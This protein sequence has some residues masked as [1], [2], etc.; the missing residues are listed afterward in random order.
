MTKIRTHK[1]KI[2]WI[3]CG[4]L[5]LVIINGNNFRYNLLT[6]DYTYE[7]NETNLKDAGSWELFPFIIDD[8][9]G[10]DYT[11]AEAVTEEW[12]SG[13]GTSINPYIIENIMIDGLDSQN[14]IT[15]RYS[16]AYFII[17]DSLFYNGRIGINLYGAP[18][19]IIINNTI[20]SNSG[21]GIAL[22]SDLLVTENTIYSNGGD[23]IYLTGNGNTISN[24]VI[25]NNNICGI[26]LYINSD[27]N[28]ISNNIMNDSGM[29]LSGANNNVITGNI[30][31]RG[32]I[33]L[34][35]AGASYGCYNN[36]LTGNI[37]NNGGVE[38]GG[39]T[40][41]EVAS[42]HI[43][44]TNLV[45]GKPLY[46]YTNEIGLDI[47]DFN[48]AGQVIL[49]NCRDSL[50]SNLDVSHT[51][52]IGDND[53]SSG[54]LLYYSSNNIISD[55]NA[56]F[57]NTGIELIYS[58]DNTIKDNNVSNNN[59]KGI[60]TTY[61]NDIIISGNIANDNI[62]YGINLF[63]G[64]GNLVSGN[65]ANN[66]QGYDGISLRL[67]DNNIVLRNT[68][69]N[70]ENCGIR[71]RGINN[72]I[73][74]N[75]ANYNEQ[76]I[77]IEV[78]YNNNNIIGNI[79]NHNYYDGMSIKS[80]Y[81]TILNNTVYNNGRFGIDLYLGK[82]N[83]ITNNTVKDNALGIR[84][85][86]SDNNLIYNNFFIG[87]NINGKDDGTNNQWDNGTIGNYWDDYEGFDNNGDGIG[88]TQYSIDGT[89]GAVDNYPIWDL[90]EPDPDLPTSFTLTSNADTP[91]TDGI[92]TLYWTNS[93][94][95]NNYSLYQNDI[96]LDSGLTEL[97]YL[98]EIYSNGSYSF[99]VIAFNN[100][101]DT[102]SNE[103]IVDI[104]IPVEPDP[105]PTPTP[106][107]IPSFNPLIIIGI[108]G[109]ISG[110]SAIVIKKR[111]F[112][113]D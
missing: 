86:K 73:S 64:D 103:I 33:G 87:N 97:Y 104:E 48:N 58:N 4:I 110:I 98:M 37:I 13:T 16:S 39:N 100:Y 75:I 49:V 77:H 10:G 20:Y 7:N 109:C 82:N 52:Y 71:S 108:I 46:Y 74:G 54:I 35:S 2:I 101:G 92:F 44:T 67:C 59:R 84:M 26:Y 112:R 31:N 65:T 105:D 83:I 99:K 66:N 57:G 80:E 5:F 34:S 21:D 88:D 60:H 107:L 51:S 81:N 106:D 27:Y 12:C 18:N 14:C 76:G 29:L 50:V 113:V 43:D 32:I 93:E 62:H 56:S 53:F 6:N 17:Q 63:N 94:Y 9:G 1:S 68:A 19:G 8:S 45:N 41:T 96:L 95:A 89:A 38:I 28:T 102:S 3:F 78:N 36:E 24:N 23:G 40:V 55:N 85:Y 30:I 79:V 69:N 42:H 47:N 25:N 72:N 90:P 111:I 61:S 22:G 11:W 91:D 15:I 70:N